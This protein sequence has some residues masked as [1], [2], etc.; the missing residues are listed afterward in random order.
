[1]LLAQVL[2]RSAAALVQPEPVGKE[3]QPPPRKQPRPT[4]DEQLNQVMSTATEECVKL[5]GQNYSPLQYAKLCATLAVEK[6]GSTYKKCKKG[7]T[8]TKGKGAKSKARNSKIGKVAKSKAK[9]SKIDKTH[10][11]GRK[12]IPGIVSVRKMLEASGFFFHYWLENTT[13]YKQ[14]Q[15]RTRVYMLAIRRALLERAGVSEQRLKSFLTQY[16]EIAMRRIE[17]ETECDVILPPDHAMIR[18]QRAVHLHKIAD[19]TVPTSFDDSQMAPVVDAE[20][21][22]GVNDS[23][24]EV[25]GDEV[26]RRYGETLSL[27]HD[28]SDDDAENDENIDP[29]HDINTVIDKKDNSPFAYKWHRIHCR[30]FRRANK[31]WPPAEKLLDYVD[32]FPGLIDLCEREWQILVYLGLH[33]GM[34]SNIDGPGWVVDVSQCLRRQGLSPSSWFCCTTPKGRQF[35]VKYMRLLLGFEKLLTQRIVF[36]EKRR[37]ILLANSSDALQ[38]DLAG[39]AFS[40]V[41]FTSA[42]F[43]LDGAL[44]IL[45]HCTDGGRF[46]LPFDFLERPTCL[47]HALPPTDTAAS[48]SSAGIV[49]DHSFVTSA[50]RPVCRL[51]TAD[52]FR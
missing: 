9:N 34:S 52:A 27:D 51:A 20:Y 15:S 47:R 43:E 41:Q 37:D 16:H 1:M 45:D 35:S 10:G 40:S 49:G 21:D 31:S 33:T 50:V 13:A 6:L 39:N 48:T 24:Y 4:A 22:V 3:N 44:A 14:L 46:E 26:L 18:A 28:D 25:A 23:L 32:A 30:M 42:K 12:P 5:Y 29:K 36:S 11:K 19:L 7:K 2:K 38:G 17:A 8:G